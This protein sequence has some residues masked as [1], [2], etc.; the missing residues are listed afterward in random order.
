MKSWD[1]LFYYTPR[2]CSPIVYL[3]RRIL[4]GCYQILR[5]GVYKAVP[6]KVYRNRTNR[7]VSQRSIGVTVVTKRETSPLKSRSHPSCCTVTTPQTCATSQIDDQ[8]SPLPLRVR[9]A[10]AGRVDKVN[11]RV[12]EPVVPRFGIRRCVRAGI[13]RQ[14]YLPFSQRSESAT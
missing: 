8:T 14:P 1:A 6:V 7:T 5:M 10:E 11:P 2:L 4:V 13:K 3:C 9:N 12:V